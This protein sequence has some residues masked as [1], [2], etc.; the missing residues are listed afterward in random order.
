MWDDI[1]PRKLAG[2][3]DFPGDKIEVNESEVDALKRELFEELEMEIV[4]NKFIGQTNFNYGNFQIELHGYECQLINYEGKL[5]DHDSFLWI[6][7]LKL[8]ELNMAHADIPF[9]RM[10][11]E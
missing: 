6:D 2:Y 5:T 10:I 9:I 3:W 8:N 4:I 7:K 11:E 1:R